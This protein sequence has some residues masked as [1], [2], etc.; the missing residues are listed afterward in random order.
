MS[1]EQLSEMGGG[2]GVQVAYPVG[3]WS[4]LSTVVKVLFGYG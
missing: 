3:L 1:C 2:G 4:R